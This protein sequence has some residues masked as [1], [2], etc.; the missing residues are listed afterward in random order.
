[1]HTLTRQQ[2]IERLR[3]VGDTP[4]ALR[5]LPAWAFEQFYAAEEGRIGLEPGYRRAI[6]TALDDLMFADDATFA[7]AS[8]DITRLIRSLEHAQPTPDD[9]DDNDNDDEE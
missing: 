7:L 8:D 2:L 3:A 1:M 9:D 5:A 4:A 6:S